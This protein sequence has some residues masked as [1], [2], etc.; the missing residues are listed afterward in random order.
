MRS[1]AADPSATGG[2][3]L[4]A[5]LQGPNCVKSMPK[6]K[7][8]TIFTKVEI[9]ERGNF[10]TR[11]AKQPS[12]AARFD[13]SAVQR[14]EGFSGNLAARLH[15]LKGNFGKPRGLLECILA[16][17]APTPTAGESEEMRFAQT[18]QLKTT[19]PSLGGTVCRPPLPSF[20]HGRFRGGCGE[21]GCK[22]EFPTES[23]EP[24]S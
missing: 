6:G 14:S 21:D 22:E 10:G 19:T 12:S 5:A 7:Q 17:P 11:H 8:L 2:A 24:G 3:D 9:L 1:A 16:T 13:R 15:F 4:S 18:S 23:R 20:S